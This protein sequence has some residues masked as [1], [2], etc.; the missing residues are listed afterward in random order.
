MYFF[1]L[2]FITEYGAIKE[3]LR[4]SLEFRPS[5][6]LFPSVEQRLL[7][8]MINHYPVWRLLSTAIGSLPWGAQSGQI[9]VD[10]LMVNGPIA[11][12]LGIF[13]LGT[14]ISRLKEPKVTGMESKQLLVNYLG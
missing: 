5:S 4:A 9:A 6:C 3:C 8:F 12:S 2:D 10:P 1:L 7:L 13:L 14:Q 11:V